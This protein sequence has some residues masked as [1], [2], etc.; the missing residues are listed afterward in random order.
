[1]L[2]AWLPP[3]KSLRLLVLF[4][5]HSLG[6]GCW[7]PYANGLFAGHMAAFGVGDLELNSSVSVR[8]SSSPSAGWKG[9][10]NLVSIEKQARIALLTSLSS[11]VVFICIPLQQPEKIWLS[12]PG[13]T[14][15][16]LLGEDFLSPSQTHPLLPF[17]WG[18]RKLSTLGV[19]KL[20]WSPC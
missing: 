2:A 3:D 9:V 5:E 20:S 1:M 18:F 10:E 13:G 14:V 12:P 11:F 17:G 7:M 19:L 16:L 8:F 6:G 15:K 4:W